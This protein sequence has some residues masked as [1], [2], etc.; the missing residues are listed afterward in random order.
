MCESLSGSL[1]N[2]LG[3]DL[4]PATLAVLQS[5][6]VKLNASY[7]ACFV[8]TL[9]KPRISRLPVLGSFSNDPVSD[10]CQ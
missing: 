8:G 2:V 9:V 1:H 4:F 10:K 6:G 3:E 5:K 7:T